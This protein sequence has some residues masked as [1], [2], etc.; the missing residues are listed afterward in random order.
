MHVSSPPSKCVSS[1]RFLRTVV[2]VRFRLVGFM[3][4][5]WSDWIAVLVRFVVVIPL[6]GSHACLL[7]LFR[8]I[9]WCP[10]CQLPVILSVRTSI[11]DACQ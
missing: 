9:D 3:E 8:S 11:H 10:L 2:C 1:S 5:R 7:G 6:C 4:G